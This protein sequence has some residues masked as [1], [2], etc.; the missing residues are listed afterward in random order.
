M[1]SYTVQFK[2]PVDNP[3]NNVSMVKRG[4]DMLFE[5]PLN[6]PNAHTVTLAEL[7]LAAETSGLI[8]LST[9]HNRNSEFVGYKESVSKAV[10][11]IHKD[12]AKVNRNLCE[13]KTC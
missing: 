5:V 2:L 1:T 9:D 12:V 3:V 10:N 7:V 6:Y 4:G 11:K 8:H 13:K